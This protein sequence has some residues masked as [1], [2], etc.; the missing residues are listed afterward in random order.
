MKVRFSGNI[1][2]LSWLIKAWCRSKVSHCEFVFSDGAMIYPAIETGHVILTKQKRYMWEYTFELAISPEQE[3]VI[4]KW[5]ESQIGKP[6]DYTAIAPFNVLIPRTKKF[7]KDPKQW[8]CSEFCAMGLELIGVKLFDDEFK[9]VKPSDLYRKLKTSPFAKELTKEE[10]Q[11]I[12]S[13]I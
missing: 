2:P 13:T 6:Y 11:C 4:R 7:W 1:L 10:Q 9:K 12:L 5:A 8:M 3:F